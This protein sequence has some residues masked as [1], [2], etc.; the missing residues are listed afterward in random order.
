M[1]P[2]E[3]D[4][5]DAIAQ[6]RATGTVFD[7]TVAGLFE[8]NDDL[9][10]ALVAR[11]N[12]R[13]GDRAL[14][15]SAGKTGAL[16]QAVRRA[17]PE[18]EIVCVELIPDHV[19]ELRALGFNAIAADF[20]ELGPADL[21]GSFD[22]VVANPPFGAGRV[23]LH[24]L[25]HMLGFLAPGGRLGAIMPQSLEFRDDAF[26]T[27]TRATLEEHGARYETNAPGSFREAGTMASTVSVWLT[28]P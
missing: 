12:L 24:H 1:F 27:E 11:L 5:A 3:I 28:E 19:E 23:E 7:P 10:D 20:L 18:A 13:P 25:R 17:C 16:A 6:A 8:T 9:A 26:T 4:A 14:E 22:V 2:D 15:P 21:G